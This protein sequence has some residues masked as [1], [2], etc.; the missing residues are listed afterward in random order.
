MQISQTNGRLPRSFRLASDGI[1][2][3]GMRTVNRTPWDCELIILSSANS[4]G[5]RDSRKK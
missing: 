2:K 4:T 3:E 1:R 5:S